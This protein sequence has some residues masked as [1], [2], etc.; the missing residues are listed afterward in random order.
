VSGVV[1]GGDSGS[2]LR[3]RRRECEAL[4][5]LVASV[6]AGQSGVLV[7]RGEAGIGKSA[8]LDHAAERASGC[9]IAR[10]AGNESEMELAFA[11]LH[12]V[13][14]PLLDHLERIPAPQGTALATAFGLTTGERPDRFLVGLAALSL[15]AEVAEEQP[16]LCLVDDTQW[17][18]QASAVTLAFV[19]RRLLAEPVGM[20]FAVR[21]GIEAPGLDGLPE[22][23]IRG[24]RDADARAV[25]VEGLQAPLDPAVMDRIVA[26]THGNP[27]GLL[28]LPRAMTP[29]ELAGGFGLPSTM[30]VSGRIEAGFIRRIAD[31]PAPTQR[32]LLVTAAEPVGDA[33]VVWR[34]ARSLDSPDDAAAPAI[35]EGLLEVGG[36][37]VFRHPLVRSAAYRRATAAERQEAHRALAEATDPDIDSDRR[38]WH[39][40][41]AT[42]GPDEDV[43]AELEH[44]A[45]RAQARGG[46]AAAA[47]FLERSAALT[48][49]PAAR[50]HRMIAAAG[51]HLEAGASE[52]AGALL[53]AAEAGPL[54][55]FSRAQ[56]E[57]IRGY[58]EVMWGDSR[59]AANLLLSAAKRLEHVDVPLARSTHHAAL[60]A[61]VVAS[62]LARG[63]SL[64]EAAKA[65]RAAPAPPGPHGPRDLSLDGLAT[66]V[67]DCPAAAAPT[68]R[69]ALAAVRS[70]QLSPEERV[71]GP[72]ISIATMLWDHESYHT[73]AL[74]HV[75][76]VRHLG[77]LTML[78]WGLTSLA[79][80][81]IFAGD[82]SSAASVIA[83]VESVI[84]AT[85]SRFALYPAAQLACWRGQEAKA[86]AVI[87]TV[88][89]Q[90]LAQ[91]QGM[92]IR[93]TQSARAT[94]YNS[95]C[96]YDEALAVALEANSGPPHWATHLTLHELVEAASRSG[97]PVVA[98]KA[99]ERLSATTQASG[100][101]W[102]LGVEA[103]S[104]ALLVTGD[105]AE[106]LYLEA[107]ERLDRSPVRAEA[108]RAHL[109][110]GEWLRREN[111]RVDARQHLRTAHDSFLAMGAEAF[112]DRAGRELAAT[113]ETVRKRTV[114]THQEL[115]PQEAQI[116]R[117]AAEGATNPEI[118]A[119]L[120]L[121]ARTV[122]W[123]LRKV[124]PKLGIASRRELRRALFRPLSRT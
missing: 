80:A 6:R 37:V 113:G 87:D 56:I 81:E 64:L 39:R 88:I 19:A 1:A 46:L 57:F 84:E 59:D 44:S 73:L 79:G 12:L 100:T 95:L 105:A 49:D 70:G 25:L 9:R 43:A 2:G 99:L 82:L 13:C 93:L 69:R 103:R 32:L 3:G 91:G 102:G 55:D 40:A 4:D 94:L 67:I 66:A 62:H 124:Y 54:D 22:V 11:G 71:R 34:A 115:T 106:A 98:T 74:R 76:T 42:S 53:T 112:A 121:S 14:A 122:E 110:Y 48:L 18:D 61:A 85:G 30:S 23:S 90:A 111:R 119:A 28:E 75:E 45:G 120:F 83:A 97:E 17:L 47:A 29:E 31:L 116:A 7:L 51:A 86:E 20:V 58:S 33:L 16:L 78:P 50:V 108:A 77:A 89:D 27:L 21:E 8:L 104:R 65:A 5:G 123:H 101:D 10:V 117:L 24:L 26:E 15:L 68:L 36:R 114:D 52:A 38:A 60:D 41:L 35:E 92:A 63:T 118:G 109:L 72:G 107:V 96:R